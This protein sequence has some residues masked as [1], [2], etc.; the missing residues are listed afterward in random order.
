MNNS[1][2]ECNNIAAAAMWKTS[3][4]A[5]RI[6]TCHILEKM[7][8]R[9]HDAQE[10]LSGLVFGQLVGVFLFS[11]LNSSSLGLCNGISFLLVLYSKSRKLVAATMLSMAY[12][13]VFHVRQINDIIIKLEF[14]ISFYSV[15]DIRISQFEASCLTFL[16]PV[17]FYYDLESLRIP[18]ITEAC[19]RSHLAKVQ[20]GVRLLWKV[21]PSYYTAL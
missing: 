18:Y 10:W 17:E 11:R 8:C 20:H 16:F 4:Q 15:F 2:A 7:Q 14:A 19:V 12:I 13:C 3:M 1:S 5:H 6:V 9:L 21:I